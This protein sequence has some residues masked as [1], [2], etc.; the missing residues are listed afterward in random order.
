MKKVTLFLFLC[1]SS[2]NLSAQYPGDIAIAEKYLQ[3]AEDAISKNQWDRAKAVLERASDFSDVL[4]DISYLMA[5]AVLKN[6][7]NRRLAL[8]VLDQAIK[9]MHW[10]IYTEAQ[11][12]LL[13]AEQHLILRN[14]YAALDYLEEYKNTV[15]DSI[16]SALMRLAA[17]KG[18]NN[19]TQ[20]RHYMTE[21]L[22]LYPRDPRPIKAF[23]NYARQTEPDEIDTGLLE[24]ILKR[25]P[26][27]LESDPDLA[28]MA[29]SYI[30]D[31]EE[32]SR[33]VSSYRS[34]S[35]KPLP[36]FKPNPASIVPALNLGLLDDLDAVEELFNNTSIDKD[37]IIVIGN[38]LRSKEGRNLMAEKLHS[39]S[40][41]I[42]EDEDK[43]GFAE[44][45][46]VY[47]QGLLQ[48]Y[49]HDA[50]QDGTYNI[51]VFFKAGEI[52]LA[53]TFSLPEKE[54][55]RTEAIILWEQYPSAKQIVLGKEVYFFAPRD[56]Q[57]AAVSFIEIG[58][59]DAFS[60][61]I[62]PQINPLC[63][64]ITQL[65]LFSFASS[66]QRPSL[67]FEG[68]IEYLLLNKGVPERSEIK[69]N[70]KTVSIT[71][72]E[73]GKPVIQRMDLLYND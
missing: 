2:V 21:T 31:T 23:F 37:L 49:F 58:A 40:G 62:F 63:Q 50:D 8:A 66:V 35:I 42:I 65:M 70:D 22:S 51:K 4:S 16:E 32:A 48:E 36:D 52:Q 39:F 11:A 17:Y 29:V 28:W 64:E 44:S 27:I 18:L 56:F 68:G 7:G 73:K 61:L 10:L 34:G 33:L 72:F 1:I 20:F 45:R 19:S 6:D 24:I 71:V 57:Y 26:F 54:T 59:S 25:L 12:R 3:F 41:E 15:G 55:G 53:E 5:H 13:Q 47:K 69:I 38:L 43:D 30:A 14:Y 46:A 67:E 9:T 60:G